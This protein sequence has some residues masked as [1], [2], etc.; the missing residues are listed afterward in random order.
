VPEIVAYLKLTCVRYVCF[1]SSESTV[2]RYCSYNPYRP[3][4]D[5][6]VSTLLALSSRIIMLCCMYACSCSCMAVVVYICT[7]IDYIIN[8]VIQTE[9][10][11]IIILSYYAAFRNRLQLFPVFLLR[12]VAYLITIV[13]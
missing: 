13:Q 9:Q 2:I 3:T 7:N 12:C 11:N 5:S 10:T 8:T 1:R 6:L 4:V